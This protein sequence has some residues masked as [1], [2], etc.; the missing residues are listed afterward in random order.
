MGILSSLLMNIQ[1]YQEFEYCRVISFEP[2]E[3]EAVSSEEEAI[4]CD[5]P[6]NLGPGRASCCAQS[7]DVELR[8][9]CLAL[10][11]KGRGG[12]FQALRGFSGIFTSIQTGLSFF[13]T[14]SN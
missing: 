8:V 14:S 12:F 6:M 5:V 13:F 1:V 11:R 10:F 3:E 4:S 9:S 7:L 2:R